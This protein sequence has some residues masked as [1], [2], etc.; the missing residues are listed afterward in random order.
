MKSLV[1]GEC[2]LVVTKIICL[3]DIALGQHHNSNTKFFN[4]LLVY[5]TWHIEP[6]W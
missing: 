3:K 5:I 4:F 1:Q 2:A 6:I